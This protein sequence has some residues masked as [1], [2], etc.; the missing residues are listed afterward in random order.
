VAIYIWPVVIFF[1]GG[2]IFVSGKKRW[3]LRVSWPVKLRKVPSWSKFIV[4]LK[5]IAFL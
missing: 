4:T 2:V 1:F 5:K 3:A